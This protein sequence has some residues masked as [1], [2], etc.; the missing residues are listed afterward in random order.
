MA[1]NGSLNNMDPIQ[2]Y[3]E[4]ADVVNVIRERISQKKYFGYIIF[5]GNCTGLP[6]NNTRGLVQYVRPNG[7]LIA[8]LN[9][10]RDNEIYYGNFN[11]SETTPNWVK[12]A[13]KSDLFK[14]KLI[15]NSVE[16]TE[17]DKKPDGSISSYEKSVPL[18]GFNGY[19]ND[20]HTALIFSVRACY[21][22]SKSGNA[23]VSDNSLTVFT[24]ITGTFQVSGYLIYV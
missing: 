4:D 14:Y 11:A 6:G 22:G 15:N 19:P 20:V 16:I 7:T 5:S 23:R 12:Y 17:D 21:S 3:A 9:F 8:H 24:N 2:I 1:V 18:N 10:V 13:L